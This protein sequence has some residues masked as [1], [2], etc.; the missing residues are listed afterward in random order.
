M[1]RRTA[2]GSAFAGTSYD[3]A[4]E[5]LTPGGQLDQTFGRRGKVTT[6]FGAA[7]YE[8]ALAIQLDGKLPRLLKPR[9]G[10]SEA[11]CLLLGHAEKIVGPHHASLVTRLLKALERLLVETRGTLDNHRLFSENGTGT[12]SPDCSVTSPLG[13]RQFGSREGNDERSQDRNA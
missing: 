6:D 4:L 13:P 10:L 3:F 12:P 1:C 5:R 2:A 11:A 7:D 9:S 8:Q